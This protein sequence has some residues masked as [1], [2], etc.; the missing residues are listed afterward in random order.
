MKFLWVIACVLAALDM[1]LVA[2]GER[3]SVLVSADWAW[4]AWLPAIGWLSAAYRAARAPVAWFQ[5]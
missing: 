2:T 4:L 1:M 5:P 3:T